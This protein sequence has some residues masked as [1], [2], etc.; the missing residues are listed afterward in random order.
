MKFSKAKLV[1]SVGALAVAGM[2][3]SQNAAAYAYAYSYLDISSFTITP[4]GGISF[5]AGQVIGEASAEDVGPN[6]CSVSFGLVC[7][8]PVANSGV[9]IPN[10]SFMMH[11]GAADEFAH[12]DGFVPGGGTQAQDQVEAKSNSNNELSA[13]EQYD[14]TYDFT[15]SG[16]G[17]NDTLTFSFDALIDQLAKL[18][19][20]ALP[21]DQ[22]QSNISFNVNISNGSGTVFEWAPN[23]GG[24]AIGGSV[25]AE[26]F[27]LQTA[28]SKQN[29]DGSV[30]NVRAL[31]PFSA[32]T[33]DLADGNY[34]I[35]VNKEV[36]ANAKFHTEFV[37][38]PASIALLGLGL[39]GIGAVRR[40]KVRA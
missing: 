33:N 35:S 9:V 14:L 32:T 3:V 19:G 17:N 26:P 38:E 39:A 5:G 31:S 20:G 7:D 37:P 1:A 15:V 8:I 22:A 12:A 21:G 16:G 13:Q 34:S 23:G 6:G 4:A 30:P 11:E 40:R 28:V 18:E 27:S 29:S 10:N 24:T 36:S 2:C 25:S